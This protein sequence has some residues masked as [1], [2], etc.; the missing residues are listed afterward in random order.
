M[1]VL[2]NSFGLIVGVARYKNINPL[3]TLILKDVN[4]IYDT[5]VDPECCGYSPDNVRKLIDQEVTPEALRAEFRHLRDQCDSE[6]TVFIYF[7]GHGGRIESGE[8][9]GEY[10]LPVNAD[11]ASGEMVAR[12]AISGKDF[13]AMLHQLPARKL[14][15]FLDCC[16][17]GGIG[18]PKSPILK[19]G[20]SESF[21]E[22]LRVGRGRAIVASSR[23]T[24]SSYILQ[25]DKNS[26]FTKHLLA[27]LRGG[28][29]SDDGLIRIF[30][31]FEYIQPRVTE[32]NRNQ[33]PL[34]QVALEDNFPVALRLSGT[35]SSAA[36]LGEGFLYDAFISFADYEQDKNYAWSL[37]IPHLRNAGLR[38]A[39]AGDVEEPGVFRVVG[40]EN[41]IR[42]S[43]RTVV[44]ISPNYLGDR[45]AAFRDVL[46]QTISINEGSFRLLPVVV[47]PVEE[48]QLPERIRM[49]TII[50]LGE[51]GKS[52][53]GLERLVNALKRTLPT[54]DH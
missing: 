46:S 27:G 26:L 25:G 10:L 36:T 38:V 40:D 35:K 6:S 3:P 9:Q 17:A 1:S 50:N 52:E 28:A 18:T 54:W 31:L 33:H 49:L 37:L 51:D 42:Q 43:K 14:V 39:V 2:E 30:Q 32:E 48:A 47:G 44:I 13:S 45:W 4:D 41:A 7:S 24:E 20:F 15:V 11:F 23:S 29:I 21:Y 34:L 53:Q 12:T 8:F 16:H 5:L 22:Q 19:S